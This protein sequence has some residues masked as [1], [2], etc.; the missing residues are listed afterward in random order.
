MARIPLRAA[1]AVA[2]VAG[3]LALG[4]SPALAAPAPGSYGQRDAG[5]FRNILPP[6][7]G[8]DANVDL[9]GDRLEAGDEP[10]AEGRAAAEVAGWRE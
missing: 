3:A 10:E 8:S 9:Q 4:A 6:G 2:A 7:Q 5:G 1:A